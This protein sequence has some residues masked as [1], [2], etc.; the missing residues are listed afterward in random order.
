MKRDRNRK[1][2]SSFLKKNKM[3]CFLIKKGKIYSYSIRAFHKHALNLMKKNIYV[4][5]K[6]I[7]NNKP[8]IK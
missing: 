7:P 1:I 2:F 8:W 4:W 6:K 5:L 3:N